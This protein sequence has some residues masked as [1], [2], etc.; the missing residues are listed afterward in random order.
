VPTLNEICASQENDVQVAQAFTERLRD[1]GATVYALAGADAARVVQL[2]AIWAQDVGAIVLTCVTALNDLARI[3]ALTDGAIGA[4]PSRTSTALETY[5]GALN[6]DADGNGNTRA[7]TDGLLI[8]R[9]LR[10]ATD[11]ALIDNARASTARNAQDILNWITATHG[12]SC[13]PTQ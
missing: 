2:R 4:S 8:S 12:A 1:A 13:L 9:A 10:G 7:A 6:L 5:I 3:D 11:A